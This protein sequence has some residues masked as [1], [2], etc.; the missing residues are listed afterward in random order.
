MA[1]LIFACILM[2]NVNHILEVILLES[3]DRLFENGLELEVK[4]VDRD[5]ITF[6]NFIEDV[7]HSVFDADF[8]MLGSSDF[9][10][11]ILVLSIINMIIISFIT[12]SVSPSHVFNNKNK[13]ALQILKT[14]TACSIFCKRLKN[15]SRR[16]K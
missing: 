1:I 3:S 2:E 14:Y 4:E 6:C 5:Y 10:S 15:Y 13:I 7:Q 9:I 12:E 11:F 8:G 16:L